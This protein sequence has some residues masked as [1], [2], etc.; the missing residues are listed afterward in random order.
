MNDKCKCCGCA[1]GTRLSSKKVM[2]L[3]PECVMKSIGKTV[4]VTGSINSSVVK[5]VQNPSQCGTEPGD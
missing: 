1:W 3:F 4:G 5:L 2:C